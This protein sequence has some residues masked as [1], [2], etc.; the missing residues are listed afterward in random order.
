MSMLNEKNLFALENEIREKIKTGDQDAAEDL[1]M[2]KTAILSFFEYAHRVEEQETEKR[3]ATGILDGKE[4]QEKISYYDGTRH[5]AH[6]KAIVNVKIINRLCSMYGTGTIFTGDQTKRF[7][8][9][10]FCG[11]I[12]NYI[13]TRREL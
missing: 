7:E 13:F 3:F 1:N 4:L 6:E 11:E 9:G 2:L 12:S 8:I 5:N 10:A